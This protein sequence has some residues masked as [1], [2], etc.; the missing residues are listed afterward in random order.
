TYMFSAQLKQIFCLILQYT[1]V[2]NGIASQRLSNI[3]WPDRPADKVKN[4]RGVTLNHLRKVL[5]EL[6]GLELI[7][8]K[9]HF[10]I[11]QTN[12]F[13]CDYIRLM[14]IISVQE[15]E[16]HRGEMLEILSRGKFLQLSDHPLYDSFKEELEKK[17]EPVLIVELEK[18][19]EAELYEITIAFAEA[20]FNI[21]PLND[22]AFSYQ[23]KAMQKL[24]LN[25]EAR[26]RYQAFVIEYRKIM[27]SDYLHPY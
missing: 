2:N 4:L 14:E 18:S 19:F 23:I 24:K 5:S 15:T 7:Y 22:I 25:D 12:A 26:I 11:D 9:G 16:K 8:D 27:G 6:D 1:I 21:D 20:I 13:Y 3:L 10:K 17:L